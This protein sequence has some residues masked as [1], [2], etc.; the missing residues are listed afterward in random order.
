MHQ[1]VFERKGP[2]L[3][4]RPEIVPL[5]ESQLTVVRQEQKAQQ[6]ESVMRVQADKVLQYMLGLDDFASST[7][8]SV[9]AHVHKRHMS[10]IL[11]WAEGQ[12]YIEVEDGA[13]KSKQCRLTKDGKSYAKL[14]QKEAKK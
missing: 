12:D 10:E 2:L 3:I 9:G 6:Q 5:D 8:L 7:V 13:R 14:K 11:E 4:H 1:Q